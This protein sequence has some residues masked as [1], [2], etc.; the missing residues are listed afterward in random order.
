MRD[1]CFSLNEILVRNLENVGKSISGPYHGIER[2]N[3]SRLYRVTQ[4]NITV[5]MLETLCEI[6]LE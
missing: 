6:M 2:L 4:E 3:G 5:F 1:P